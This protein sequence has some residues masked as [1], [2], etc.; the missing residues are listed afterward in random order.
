MIP[1]LA[2]EEDMTT[3]NIGFSIASTVG[4]VGIA[5]II[6]GLGMIAINRWYFGAKRHL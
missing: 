6:I 5:G 1:R 2:W 3:V 4:S